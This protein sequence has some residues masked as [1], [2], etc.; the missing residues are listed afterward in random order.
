MYVGFDYFVYKANVGLKYAH[1]NHQNK[2]NIINMTQN[3]LNISTKQ[4]L[5]QKN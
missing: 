5:K 4:V 1:N 3:A 2:K